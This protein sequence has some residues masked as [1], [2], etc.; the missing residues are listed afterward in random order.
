MIRLIEAPG[1]PIECPVFDRR[2]FGAGEAIVGPAILEQLDTTVLI[3]PGQV[4]LVDPHGN[5]TITEDEP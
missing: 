1:D 4:G 2:D 5:L 3:L